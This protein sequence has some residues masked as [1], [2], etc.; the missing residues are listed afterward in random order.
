MAH[1]EPGSPLPVPA[2]R[3]PL[4][5][6]G[7]RGMAIGSLL[8]GV[9]TLIGAELVR[10]TPQLLLLGLAGAAYGVLSLRQQPPRARV[11]AAH[12][13]CKEV[14][15]ALRRARRLPHLKGRMPDQA[16]AQFAQNE[17]RLEH[18]E[19]LLASR[20]E[21]TELT[22][23]RYWGVAEQLHFTL[24]NQ[25][26]E[27]AT[28]LGQVSALNVPYVRRELKRHKDRGPMRQSLEERLE[29]AVQVERRAQ[30]VLVANERALTELDRLAQAV[31]AIQ[32]TKSAPSQELE[33]LLAELRELAS[34][35]GRYASGPTRSDDDH[36]S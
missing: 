28:L 8:A 31:G 3:A 2:P 36:R 1:E 32:T 12:A 7:G 17:E 11:P 30:E 22:Y 35:A 14:R 34:R 19:A 33:A 9:A 6:P 25:L 10:P 15:H 20:F 4:L 18:F 26:L 24:G 5:L 13:S 29:L 23:G 21:R 16:L 27:L